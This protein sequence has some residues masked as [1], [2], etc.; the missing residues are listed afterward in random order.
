[1]INKMRQ[2]YCDLRLKR[3]TGKLL[4]QQLNVTQLFWS[5]DVLERVGQRDDSGLQQR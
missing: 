2:L 3:K 4:L 1:M 5:E